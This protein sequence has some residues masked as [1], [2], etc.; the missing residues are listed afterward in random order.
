[1]TNNTKVRQDLMS[2]DFP[3]IWLEI[4]RKNKANI[5]S[6]GF[7]REW[8]RNGDSSKE[9]QIESIKILTQQIIE[10]TSTNKHTIML[11]DANLFMN[12]WENTN[13]T[14]RM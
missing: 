8:T 13:Y 2:E 4:E 5:I 9:S 1:M 6:G 10:A 3:S 12:K 7:Y 11:G 14:Q